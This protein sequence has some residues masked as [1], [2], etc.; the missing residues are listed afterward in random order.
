M[1]DYR[2][3]DIKKETALAIIVSTH[4]DGD[5]PDDAEALFD[6][7]MGERAPQL[8]ALRYSVLAL[9]DS[10]Y[11]YFCKT[12][13]DFDERLAALGA[14]RFGDRVELDLDYADAAAAWSEATLDAAR[15]LLGEPG[16]GT[17]PTLH[18]VS[19]TRFSVDNP[20]AADVVVNQKITGTRVV[21]RRPPHRV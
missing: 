3:Q 19:G 18:A 6:Y 8:A 10:S 7:L 13:V 1:A 14:Q 2:V 9:G 12:G 21:K 4:G 11:P 17:A 5:P 16:V 20:L 15:D